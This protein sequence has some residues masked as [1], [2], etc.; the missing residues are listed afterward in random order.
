MAVFIEEFLYRGKSDG[1]SAWHVVLGTVVDD[2]FGDKKLNLKG[3]MTPAQA[4]EGGYPLPA[5]LSAINGVA[6]A[7]LEATKTTLK[8]V[9][10]DKKAVEEQAKILAEQ[11]ELHLEAIAAKDAEIADLQAEKKTAEQTLDVSAV[12]ADPA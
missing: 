8:V 1:A 2:G 10:A 4:E 5:I 9:E 12:M 11:A 6:L 3:P 7:E